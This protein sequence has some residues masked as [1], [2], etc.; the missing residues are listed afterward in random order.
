MSGDKAVGQ[1]VD[2]I[3][4]RSGPDPMAAKFALM[5]HEQHHRR[6]KGQ[7]GMA[8]ADRFELA[9]LHVSLQPQFEGLE[10]RLEDGLEIVWPDRTLKQAF[11]QANRV[12]SADGEQVTLHDLHQAGPQRLRQGPVRPGRQ[13]Q[14]R[15]AS[16]MGISQ[17]SGN[18]AFAVS[19]V[20][21]QGGDRH[22]CRRGQI[23]QGRSIHLFE[24]DSDA[25]QQPSTLAVVV[26]I[27]GAD[28][29]QLRPGF[30]TMGKQ[31]LRQRRSLA[32]AVDRKALAQRAVKRDGQEMFALI[33]F[34]LTT[35]SIAVSQSG[36][37]ISNEIF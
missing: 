35:G 36:F 26:R 25:P 37:Y 4:S 8:H 12:E 20:V 15:G 23:S 1:I 7:R 31:R 28:S 18:H 21:P 32:R 24:P 29:H 16:R 34:L 19:K 30:L 27:P 14:E 17:N 3:L 13:G 5:Q 6:H 11:G 9:T 33:A 10:R 2:Q 22:F